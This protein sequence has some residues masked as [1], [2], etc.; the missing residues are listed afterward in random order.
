MH[1]I[2]DTRMTGVGRRNFSMFKKL[3][4][5]DALKNIVIVTNMWN[6]VP[7]ERGIA[8]ENQLATDDKF[9]KPVLERGAIMLRHDNT[10]SSTHAILR[11]IVSNHPKALRIQ[12]ELVDEHKDITQTAAGVELNH[13]LAALV[14]KHQEELAQ[15]HQEMQ[16]ALLAKDEE[17]KRELD[18]V[19]SELMAKIQKIE[20][21]REQMSEQYASQKEYMNGQVDELKRRITDLQSTVMP[22]SPK[23]CI[24]L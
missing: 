10:L 1:R 11:R 14:K 16:D 18:I 2:T 13:E 9:F 22:E 5:D 17:M 6:D 7:E 15:L 8:R 21:D 19:R 3:C 24:I 23:H 20:R 12:Q 4:G